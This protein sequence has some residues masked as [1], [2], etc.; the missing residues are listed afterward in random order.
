MKRSIV[1]VAAI[2]IAALFISCSN[3]MNTPPVIIGGGNSG[4]SVSSVEDIQEALANGASKI[5]LVDDIEVTEQ[6]TINSGV[7]IDGRN[8][9]FIVKQNADNTETAQVIISGSGV[10]LSNVTITVSGTQGQAL[11]Q[12]ENPSEETQ[13]DPKNGFALLIVNASSVTLE[14]VTLTTNNLTSGINVY[15]SKNVTIKNLNVDNCQRAPINISASD[16]TIDGATADG[17]VWYGD[18]NVIQVNGLGG[19]MHDPDSTIN[20]KSSTVT[21]SNMGN[22]DAVWQEVVAANY[23]AAADIDD[24]SATGQ[25]SVALD[26][27]VSLLIDDTK[28]KGWMIVPGENLLNIEEFTE[29]NYQPLTDEYYWKNGTGKREITDAGALN[30]GANNGQNQGIGFYFGTK[31]S[32]NIGNATQSFENIVKSGDIY[33]MQMDYTLNTGGTLTFGGNLHA[34]D[35]QPSS[36]G[37]GIFTPIS[38]PASG[39]VSVIMLV[40]ENGVTYIGNMNMADPKT[41]SV[42]NDNVDFRCGFTAWGDC[43]VDS[44]RVDKLNLDAS[45]LAGLM[46]N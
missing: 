43:L 29:N 13:T 11:S 2:L 32:M 8:N 3:S 22:F 14:D 18:L 6:L 37:D 34:E 17:S 9:S 21:I 24:I 7:T 45:K 12:N 33:L 40:N 42:T 23:T 44:I 28:S 41:I 31:S 10:T 19:S 25:S 39:T 15:N 26:G 36:S 35:E 38:T 1:A 4:T 16:V 5:R 30:M 27:G 20:P 46:G